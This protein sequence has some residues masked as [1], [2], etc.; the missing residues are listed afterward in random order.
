MIAMASRSTA[1][2]PLRRVAVRLLCGLLL[3]AQQHGHLHAHG[4]EIPRPGDHGHMFQVGEP[5]VVARQA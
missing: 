5:D 1:F 3:V 2:A 4:G